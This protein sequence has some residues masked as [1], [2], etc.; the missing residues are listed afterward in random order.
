MWTFQGSH[1]SYRPALINLFSDIFVS[2]WYWCF[3]VILPWELFYHRKITLVRWKYYILYI[4]VCVSIIDVKHIGMC[5]GLVKYISNILCLKLKKISKNLGSKKNFYMFFLEFYICIS[6]LIIYKTRCYI[7]LI[8]Y[9]LF[10]IIISRNSFQSSR[11]I[12]VTINTILQLR[13][14]CD[15]YELYLD[16]VLTF[17]MSFRMRKK[18]VHG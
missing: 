17:Q 15:L 12:D 10:I 14:F 13:L 3:H 2:I 11:N 18:H 6:T 9:L 16:L 5:A 4:R 1:I 8:N 7:S